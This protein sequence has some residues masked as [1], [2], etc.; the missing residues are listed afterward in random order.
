MTHSC[1]GV[2]LNPQTMEYEAWLVSG[3]NGKEYQI[4]GCASELG[5]DIVKWWEEEVWHWFIHEILE[6]AIKRESS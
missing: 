1:T 3:A 5:P 2:Y 4:G 6:P